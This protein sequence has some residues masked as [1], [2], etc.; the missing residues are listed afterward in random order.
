MKRISLLLL[1]ALW[2]GAHAQDAGYQMPPPAIADLLLAKP[3][4]SPSV[5][6]K[7]EWMILSQFNS[8]PSVEE[9]AQPELKI[10]GLRLNPNNFGPSRRTYVSAYTLRS[11]S[12]LQDFAI[13]GLPANLLGSN[14]SWSPNYKKA[15]FTHTSN[16]AIDLYVIDI[17][18]KKATKINKQPLNAVLGSPYAWISDEALVYKAIT[19]PASAA[20]PKPLKPKGPTV[21]Q[22]IG[23][24]APSPTFQDLIKS[25]YDEEL[26]AFMANSQLVKWRNGVETKLGNADLH[27]DIQVSPDQQ[28]LLLNTIN[29][30]FS[31]LVQAYSFPATYTVVD[32]NGKTIA[33]IAKNP[34]S[35]GVPI[36]YDNVEDF[37]RDI[38]WRDDEPATIVYTKALDSGVFK[39]NVTHHDALY[40]LSAPFNGPAKEWTKV[41]KRFY[42]L[43][44]TNSNYAL[45]YDGDLG[46]KQMRLSK[47]GN[48]NNV[49]EEIYTRSMDDGYNNPGNPVTAKN[50]FG[51]SVVATFDG[52]T[53]FMTN[54]TQGASAKGD[55]PFLAVFDVVK[56]EKNI[57]WRCEEGVYE[58]A[59]VVLNVEKQLVLTRK[60]SQSMVPNLYLRDLKNNTA[61]AVTSF[62]DPQPVLRKVRKEKISYKRSDG[63][64]LTATVYLPEGYK[65]GVDKPLPVFMWAYPREFK[66]AADAAQ[67]RGSQNTFTRIGWG[68]IVFH[69]TQ[70]YCIMD[71]TEFPIVGEGDKEPN[72][73]FVEQLEMNARAAI[74]KIAQLGYGDSTR[75]AVGGHSYGSFMTANLLA[76]TN[77]FKAGIARSG[78]H[79]R[80][81]TPFGFQ[82]E[83][84]TYWQAPEIYFKMS[85]FSYADKI[86]TPLLLIHGDADNNPGTFPIQSERL[87][88]AIKGQG[89][90]VRYVSLPYESHGYQG[91]ENI[92][93]MLWEQQQWLDKWLK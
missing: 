15:A 22:S 2:L 81:L 52:G 21:Q 92:L 40:V 37:P 4:P 28:Y 8:Y 39:N 66:S 90:K 75:V 83:R 24:A 12:S 62:P 86:K 76:H 87:Y 89:G 78:A 77:L 85:P 33:T 44:F 20:P 16:N 26:F 59:A 31:Y 84:R 32:L 3:T 80:T 30:P 25:P 27:N 91:R 7:G 69:V 82:N 53:K 57:V 29:K 68:S 6:D 41:V 70:G 93:H 38:S 60:E 54:N 45:L 71:E 63:V 72:D 14:L 56:K 17:A 61:K 36:G 88:N 49:Q 65:P 67:V 9:L 11:L 79:N 5:D 47:L 48:S 64:D 35:E 74:E 50:K 73:N 10:A 43:Q 23:K 58:Y 55:L 13:A 18:T 51:A 46:K 19:K 1:A 42:G 34:S